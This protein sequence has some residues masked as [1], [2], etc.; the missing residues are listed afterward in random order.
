MP[1]KTTNKYVLL[2]YYI[3]QH[4]L[5]YSLG[6]IAILATN[7]IAVSIP[8]YV[9]LS[10]DLLNNDLEARQDLLWEYMI[11]MLGLAVVMIF[12][13][14]LSRILFFN[15]GRAI[16]CQIKNDMFHKL[17]AL[18]KDY[19]ESNPSGNIISRI[20]NDITGVRMIC[21]FGLMQSFN[22]T[23]A[24][25]MTPF[26][27]WQL[28]PSLTLYCIIPI[29]LVFTAV[30]L[31]MHALVRNMQARMESL[32]RLSGFRG[33]IVVSNRSDQK[34]DYAQLEQRSF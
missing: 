15:P 30:R 19:Y 13:R 9:R 28:S 11:I 5:S 33:I 21:G 17:M 2:G 22:I 14:T 20:N 1:P 32:Q 6:I 4:W 27:M 18:Q 25:S 3:K 26:K 34:P 24:L 23:S 7:W 29:L 12:V 10:I 31:G 8:E 16:E